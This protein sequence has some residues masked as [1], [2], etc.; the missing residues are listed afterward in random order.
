MMLVIVEN[1][2]IELNFFLEKQKKTYIIFM[3]ENC[4]IKIMLVE[5]SPVDARLLQRFVEDLGYQFC[6]V[7]SSGEEAVILAVEK[8]PH[9]ILMDI[10][11]EDD[12]SGIDAAREIRK[13]I[14]V[15]IIYS[16]SHSDPITL[17][18]INI[19]DA[20][21]FLI[22]PVKKE[23]LAV[24]IT[25]ALKRREFEQ[26]IEASELRY[27]I[28]LDGTGD[29][30]FSLDEELNFLGANKSI[31]K[32][33]N[34]P[35][36]KIKDYH[37]IDLLY[38]GIEKPVEAIEFVKNKVLEL[39]KTGVPVNFKAIFTSH[40]TDEPKELNV[41]LERIFVNNRHEIIGK[42]TRVVDDALMKH[43]SFERQSWTIGNY[44]VTAEEITYR[45]TRNINKYLDS[46]KV[47]FLRIGLR[48]ILFNS[49]EHGNLAITYDEKT[50]AQTENKYFKLL[51]SRQNDSL[52]C[53]KVITIDYS[54]SEEK[55]VYHVTDQ[56]EGF[57]LT[58]FHN[59][60]ENI[61]SE[62]SHGRGIMMANEA[63]DEVNYHGNG[64]EV[65][66]IKYFNND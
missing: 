62:L 54:V 18:Q 7:T 64:N 41:Q 20:Y 32:V 60:D 37:F 35:L 66:L 13:E 2:F 59:Q 47:N 15:P 4:D 51:K 45:L 55:V 23:Y 38:S 33:L 25:M 49:I 34:I 11:L 46:E 53:N 16:T 28:L 56:G 19:I 42:A 39:K 48:E 43:I 14:P 3:M 5:D 31:Q 36:R 65:E 12:F 40:V 1:F 6:G 61:R 8:R 57:D 22:K 52:Y 21:G 44:L 63:F 29:I 9:C 50:K 17:D 10:E 27:R 58:I 26:K 24:A 30:I